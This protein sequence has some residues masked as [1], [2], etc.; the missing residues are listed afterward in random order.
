MKRLAFSRLALCVLCGAL[1]TGPSLAFADWG[2]DVRLTYNDSLSEP[3]LN[4]AQCIGVD[5]MGWVHLVWRDHRDGNDEVYYKRSTDWGTTWE[6]DV[7]LTKHPS[8]SRLPALAIDRMG[9]V[10]VA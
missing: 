9:G 1:T 3:C 7:R 2:P 6:A 10:H 8:Y 4:N 5:S